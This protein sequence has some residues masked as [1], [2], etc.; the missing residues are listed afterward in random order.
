MATQD[1]AAALQRV[2]SVLRRRPSA[3]LHDDA[4]ATAHWEGGT[5]VIASHDNGKQVVSDMPAELGGSGDQVT[6]GWLLRAG[7]A[8]CTATCIALAAAADG[9]ELQALEVQACSRSDTRGLLGLADGDGE[10]VYAGPRDMQM[11]VKISAHGVSEQRLRELIEKSYRSSPIA[12][13]LLNAVPVTLRIEVGA[14]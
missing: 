6:P 3:G 8:S 4:S 13:A 9:V 11:H 14:D 10:L 5:R 7:F 1:I 2:E 12:C